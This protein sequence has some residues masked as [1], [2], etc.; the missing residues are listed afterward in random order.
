M[1]KDT[2]EVS[3][4]IKT[5]KSKEATRRLMRE[6]DMRIV[7]GMFK[8]DELRGGVLK[9]HY[10]KYKEVPLK[11]YE[12]VDG[13][14]YDLPYMV[15]KHLNNHCWYPVHQYMHDEAGK[16]TARIGEKIHRVSFI[17]LDFIDMEDN[18]KNIVTVEKYS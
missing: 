8:Y 11:N 10:K 5:S 7:K 16:V 15:A 1:A 13:Q 3:S 6:K 17:P 2:V 14:V 12:L 18:T 4:N 9:F